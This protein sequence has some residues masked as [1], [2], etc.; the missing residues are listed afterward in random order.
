MP[1]VRCRDDRAYALHI[2]AQERFVRM[3]VRVP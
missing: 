2:V 1:N 3:I